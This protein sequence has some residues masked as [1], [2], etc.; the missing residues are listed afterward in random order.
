MLV[1]SLEP[2]FDLTDN[3][4]EKQRSAEFVSLHGVADRFNCR[5][6]TEEVVYSD[7]LVLI[8]LVCEIEVELISDQEMSNFI[9]M[10]KENP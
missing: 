6:M 9:E 8:L 10:R 3:K 5:L 7:F 2:E 1:Q 4:N